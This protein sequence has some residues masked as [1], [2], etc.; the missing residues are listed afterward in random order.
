MYISQLLFLAIAWPSPAH[1]DIPLPFRASVYLCIRLPNLLDFLAHLF[2]FCFFLCRLLLLIFVMYASQL[3]KRHMSTL[4][5][6]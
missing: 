2:H 6:S 4:T 1:H 3:E 5:N